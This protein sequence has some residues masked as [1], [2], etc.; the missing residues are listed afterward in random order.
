MKKILIVVG[1]TTI[2][3]SNAFACK[4]SE[5]GLSCPTNKMM[6]IHQNKSEKFVEAILN[7]FSKTAPSTEQIKTAK[8]AVE[9]FRD[10]MDELKEEKK[11]PI[12][13]LTESE[14]DKDL[15]VSICLKKSAQKIQSKVEF[16]DEV[17]STLDAQ[18]KREFKTEFA[19]N[20]VLE[21]LIK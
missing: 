1:V 3:V 16:I 12:E 21:E 9:K 8:R 4:N 14:F 5:M 15:F 11:F 10:S 13:T 6:N 17:Y 7:A 2:L 18:Q 19:S 20:K